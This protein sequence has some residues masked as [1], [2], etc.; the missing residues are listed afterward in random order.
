MN[1]EKCDMRIIIGQYYY[2]LSPFLN[3]PL[4]N[5]AAII[6]IFFLFKIQHSLFEFA[7]TVA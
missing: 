5:F 2:Q 3:L 6:Y 4:L 7:R 1:Y